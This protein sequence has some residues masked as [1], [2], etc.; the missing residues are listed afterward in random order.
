MREHGSWGFTIQL[1]TDPEVIRTVRKVIAAAARIGGARD[2]DA[3][4]IELSVG[5]ALANARFHAYENGVG[6]IEATVTLGREMFSVMIQN[7]GKPVT[8]RAPVPETLDPT[9]SQNWGLY[10]LG[11]TMDEVEITR[12]TLDDRGTAIRM[13]KR[14]TAQPR[15]G[16][17]EVPLGTD[18]D[19]TPQTPHQ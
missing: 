4:L 8:S 1:E 13:S 9:E 12:S 6:P 18:R 17:E 3:R 2:V 7:A 5:E 11:R 14:L 15:V 19:E 16:T 10:L